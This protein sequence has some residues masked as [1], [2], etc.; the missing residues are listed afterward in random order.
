MYSVVKL[1][2]WLYFIH[3]KLDFDGMKEK[4]N[5]TSHLASNQLV[6]WLVELQTKVDPNL[7]SLIKKGYDS[8]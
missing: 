2:F 6:R 4:Y 5:P 7:A 1:F 8:M 3:F